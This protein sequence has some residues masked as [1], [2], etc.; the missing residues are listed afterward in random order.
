MSRQLGKYDETEKGDMKSVD[1]S[2]KEKIMGK[3]VLSGET[4]S[5]VSDMCNVSVAVNVEE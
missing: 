3:I 2:D 1:Q 4:Q 5:D